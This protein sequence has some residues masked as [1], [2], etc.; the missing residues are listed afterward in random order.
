MARIFPDLGRVDSVDGVDAVDSRAA[1]KPRSHHRGCTEKHK[2]RKAPGCGTICFIE[3]KTEVHY[4]LRIS[5][6]FSEKTGGPD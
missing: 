5:N 1:T 2:S 4:N 3:G 6:A